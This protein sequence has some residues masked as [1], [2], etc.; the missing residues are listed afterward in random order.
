MYGR[1]KHA[2]ISTLSEGFRDRAAKIHG[3]KYLAPVEVACKPLGIVLKE[4]SCPTNIDF[5]S[6][7]CEGLDMEVLQSMDWNTYNVRLVCVEHS[8]S[9]SDLHAYMNSV[10]Y[11]FYE[12][13]IG[14][15]FF[16]KEG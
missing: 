4:Y 6:I 10:G 7:D 1:D 16:E 3:N 13:T 14:N 11:T 9:K 5:L 2:Q 15:S 8:M 12:E